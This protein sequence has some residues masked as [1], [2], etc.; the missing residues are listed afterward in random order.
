M[1]VL[2][3]DP[4]SQK[5]YTRAS[6]IAHVAPT[7][8]PTLL[9]HGDSDNVVPFQESVAME[10]ALRDAK[11]PVQLVRIAGGG[12][13]PTFGVSGK[14][15]SQLPETLIEMVTW[16]DRHLKSAMTSAGH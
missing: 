2:P 3:R 4:L 14:P 1:G 5:L 13:G 7:S 12:H 16:L 8:P 15:H 6:P 10:K 9:L 11:V